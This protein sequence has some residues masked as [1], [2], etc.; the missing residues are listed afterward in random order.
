MLIS[1]VSEKDKQNIKWVINIILEQLVCH[2]GT[3]EAVKYAV[4]CLMKQDN[5]NDLKKVMELH[6]N[7]FRNEYYKN[8]VVN[9][10]KKLYKEKF[11]NEMA[12]LI[13]NNTRLSNL[14]RDYLEK[15]YLRQ[16]TI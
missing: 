6:E 5:N 9:E 13:K 10:V 7:E 16:L 15:K 12:D 8:F 4:R 2:V 11:I 3:L 14:I 1:L